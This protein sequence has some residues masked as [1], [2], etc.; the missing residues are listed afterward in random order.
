MVAAMTAIEAVLNASGPAVEDA[1]VVV[2]ASL[3]VTVTVGPPAAVTAVARVVVKPLAPM[4]DSTLDAMLESTVRTSVILTAV[5]AAPAVPDNVP[6]VSASQVTALE[7][8]RAVF[9]VPIAVVVK[10]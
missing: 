9:A 5:V 3:P 8:A 4:V 6:L 1:D 7:Y 10:S 2:A